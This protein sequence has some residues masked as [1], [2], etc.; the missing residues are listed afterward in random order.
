MSL[1]ANAIIRRY[2]TRTS[3]C[4]LVLKPVHFK[5]G[6]T[7]LRV[8]PKFIS[9]EDSLPI[10]PVQL[11]DG[12]RSIEDETELSSRESSASLQKLA[13]LNSDGI[14][15]PTQ[16]YTNNQMP[17]SKAT[18]MRNLQQNGIQENITC[19][20]PKRAH[21]HSPV[22]AMETESPNND[23]HSGSSQS[24]NTANFASIDINSAFGPAH[25]VEQSPQQQNNVLLSVLMQAVQQQQLNCGVAQQLKSTNPMFGGLNQN[26]IYGNYNQTNGNAS[27]SATNL[28]ALLQQLQQQLNNTNN[29]ATPSPTIA[30]TFGNNMATSLSHPLLFANAMNTNCNTMNSNGTSAFYDP[31]SNE[32]HKVNG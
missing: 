22:M 24:L 12:N 2:R 27:S 23:Y 26:N 19:E 15:I 13:L 16:N 21:S 17:I 5:N 1:R 7:R 14:E 9:E 3:D 18:S 32:L 11:R 29:V 6:N 25:H 20:Q 4:G 8:F 28:N 10:V 31:K 30:S